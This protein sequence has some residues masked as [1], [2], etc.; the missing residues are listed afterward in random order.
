MQVLKQQQPAFNHDGR[1]PVM[2]PQSI[3]IFVGRLVI[4]Y[5]DICSG[6]SLGLTYYCNFDMRDN[7]FETWKMYL[8]Y[9]YSFFREPNITH[10]KM[11]HSTVSGSYQ[12]INIYQIESCWSN[13]TRKPCCRRK[14]ARCRRIFRCVQF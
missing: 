1:R 7:Y 8:T 11:N 3:I 2:L 14:T 10:L 4:D 12:F 13:S 6:W 5:F 9:T